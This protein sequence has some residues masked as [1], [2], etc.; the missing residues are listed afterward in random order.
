[1]TL[2]EFTVSIDPSFDGQHCTLANPHSNAVVDL[3]GDCLAGKFLTFIP[4]S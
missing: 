4:F 3:D 1:M 2:D